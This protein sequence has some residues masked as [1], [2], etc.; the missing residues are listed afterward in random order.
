MYTKLQTKTT[1][2]EMKNYDFPV[3]AVYLWVND[4][5]PEWQARR[6]EAL[7]KANLG[8]NKK[9]TEEALAAARFRDNSELKYSLRSLERFAPWINKV[10]LI[11]DRQCP[12]WLNLEYINLVD[13]TQIL[14]PNS[15]YPLFNANPLELAMHRIPGLTEHFLAFNDDFMLGAPVSVKNFFM[16][17]GTPK[18][19]AA[20]K[21]SKKRTKKTASSERKTC[22]LMTRELIY[23]KYGIYFA[24]K[25]KHY[26]RSYAK[27][28]MNLLWETF[29]EEVEKTLQSTFYNTENLL[30]TTF[31]PLYLL[32]TNKGVLCPI[33]GIQQ[34]LHFLAGQTHHVGASLGD[35]NYKAKIKR[36]KFLK[37]LTFCVNDSE[38]ASQA[39]R[40]YLQD[41]LTSMFP[42]KSKFEL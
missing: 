23:N 3:D 19:W 42:E 22:E 30:T 16:P 41:F 27:S 38:N 1:E 17:N 4:Q 18:I 11:T 34:F 36:I 33:N 2:Y 7:I 20:A 13:H 21:N 14:P 10:H 37:P 28:S 31:Y 24:H 35:K 12:S 39:D 40:A 15:A 29:P 6:H 32:A 26:P 9:I 8:T 5:D 25:I